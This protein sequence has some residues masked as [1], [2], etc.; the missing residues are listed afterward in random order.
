MLIAKV[1]SV[2]VPRREWPEL[3]PT[4]LG[5]MTTDTPKSS[6]RQATLETLGYVCEELAALSSFQLD[7]EFV[8]SILTAVVRGMLK[9]E[10]DDDVRLAATRALNNALD[11]AHSNFSN[12]QE[13]TYI[14][15][16]V[17]EGTVCPTSEDVRVAS[18]ECLIRICQSYYDHLPPYMN[19]IFKLTLHTI[20]A[21]E[22]AV[23]KQAVELWCTLC[24]EELDLQETMEHR[25][26][27]ESDVL[28]NLV[29]QCYPTLVP[30]LLN[31][32]TK[33]E[34]EQELDE[35]AWTLSM[36]AGACLDLVALCIG[37]DV[38]PI[39]LDYVRT[40]LEHREGED[41]WRFREAATFAL[42]SILEGARTLELLHYV[43]DKFDVLLSATRDP[44]PS[45]RNTTAWTLGMPRSPLPNLPKMTGLVVRTHL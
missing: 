1:A 31:Q 24:E 40:Y 9:E 45:V 18:Y 3:I 10:R 21:D 26:L 33:Q 2:D 39:V 16:V 14:M 42:G 8:N 36:A 15:H 20:Q 25:I 23:A 12:E 29:R 7:Q 43:Q 34:E 6:V 32:L 11:F 13:R 35:T 22:E 28:H 4:L 5:N 17:C 38:V 44:D 27:D 19:E 41:S 30:L 37:N